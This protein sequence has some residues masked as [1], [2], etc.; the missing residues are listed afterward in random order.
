MHAPA[1]TCTCTCRWLCLSL[2]SG[3]LVDFH[4]FPRPEQAMGCDTGLGLVAEDKHTELGNSHWT[5]NEI[6]YVFCFPKCDISY[7]YL[8]EDRATFHTNEGKV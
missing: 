4:D 3:L 5:K 7:I 8:V 2:R 6:S 1:I